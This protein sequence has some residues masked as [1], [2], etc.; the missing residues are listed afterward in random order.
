MINQ[1]ITRWDYMWARLRGSR[2]M[3]S[4]SRKIE[5]QKR[6][7][8]KPQLIPGNSAGTILAK[9]RDVAELKQTPNLLLWEKFL[10]RIGWTNFGSFVVNPANPSDWPMSYAMA[11]TFPR[12]TVKYRLTV[13]PDMFEIC[14]YKHFQDVMDVIHKNGYL[15]CYLKAT[16]TE[17]LEVEVTFNFMSFYP[18]HSD[19]MKYFFLH[20]SL[21]KNGN[22]IGQFELC[23]SKEKKYY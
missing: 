9:D 16:P 22:L 8:Q 11:R 4:L 15:D 23:R 7:K 3:A 14:C 1:N 6:A 10:K 20:G 2:G 18:E 19:C 5:A 21:D 17:E 13:K 12:L